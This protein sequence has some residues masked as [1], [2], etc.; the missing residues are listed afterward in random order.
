MNSK[1]L[2]FPVLKSLQEEFEDTKKVIII[3]KLKKDTMA[4]R[5]RDTGTNNDQQNITLKTKNR[6]IKNQLLQ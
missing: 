2:L 3:R 5:K 4:K 1:L 6:A